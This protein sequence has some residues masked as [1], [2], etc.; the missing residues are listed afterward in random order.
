MGTK[1]PDRWVAEHFLEHASPSVGTSL[2]EYAN[3]RPRRIT[4]PKTKTTNTPGLNLTIFIGHNDESNRTP[5]EG[6]RGNLKAGVR[7]SG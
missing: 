1:R 3:S 5:R 7:R 6:G 2:I 4:P